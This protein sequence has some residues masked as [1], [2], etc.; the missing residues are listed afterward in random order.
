MF[1]KNNSSSLI[2]GDPSVGIITRRKDKVDYLKMIANLCYTSTIEPTSVEV[3]LK[4]EYWINVMQEKL[5][6]FK[7]NNV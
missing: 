6:Q 2:I 4:D 1:G 5:L 7:R 3:A